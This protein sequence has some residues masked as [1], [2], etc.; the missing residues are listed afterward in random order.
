MEVTTLSNSKYAAFAA[1]VETGSLTK[2]AAQ[3]GYTQSGVSHLIR[4]LEQEVGFSLLHRHKNGVQLTPEGQ[5]LMPYIQQILTAEKDIQCLCEELRGVSA[6]HIIVGTFSS[7]AIAW[8]P[9]LTSRFSALHPGIRLEIRNDTYSPLEEALLRDQVDCAFVPAPSK[10]EFLTWPVYRD[11]LMA[12]MECTSPLAEKSSLTAQELRNLPYIVPAEG[13][14]YDAGKLFSSAG[15]SPA[16]RFNAGD[17][18]AA[19]AMVRKGLGFTILP[20]LLLRDT[21]VDGLC[22]IPLLH[23]ERKICIAVNKSRFLSPALQ[24][25]ITFVRETVPSLGNTV[26]L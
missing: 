7:A 23:S 11:R 13:T 26:L 10:E 6:G 22:A 20:E 3:L 19:L 24:S 5:R 8:M 25:F 17:D 18:Y 21:R 4:A 14:N 16:I 2:A 12:V 15:V 1:A 9:E